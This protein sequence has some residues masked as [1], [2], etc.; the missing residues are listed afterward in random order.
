MPRKPRTDSN[1][2]NVKRSG[3]PRG[4]S[5]K[6]NATQDKPQIIASVISPTRLQLLYNEITSSERNIG[7]L[8]GS[9]AARKQIREE[10]ALITGHLQNHAGTV[11]FYLNNPNDAH[12][13]PNLTRI[14]GLKISNVIRAEDTGEFFDNA[15]RKELT[16][17]R[18]RISANKLTAE[19]VLK[20]HKIVKKIAE[21]VD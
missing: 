20:L 11:V 8:T 9:E 12:E 1:T 13:Y 18:L 21:Y 19:D 2:Q 4:G 6:G 7:S 14:E 16:L 17:L 3:R 5:R 10:S 15:E